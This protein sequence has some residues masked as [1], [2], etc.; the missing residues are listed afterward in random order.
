MANKKNIRIC[1]GEKVCN[2]HDKSED[3]IIIVF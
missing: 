3:V 1:I 2:S